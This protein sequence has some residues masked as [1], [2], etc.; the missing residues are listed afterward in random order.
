[1]P[2][3]PEVRRHAD[4]LHAALAGKPLVSLWARTKAAKGWLAEHGA[5]V[6]GRPVE[7]VFSRGKNLSTSI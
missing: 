4:N 2:E 1:M 7:R 5:D 3:G 6:V